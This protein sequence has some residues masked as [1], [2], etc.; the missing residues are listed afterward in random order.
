M[1]RP[2]VSSV[3]REAMG[4]VPKVLLASTDT[5]MAVTN[6]SGVDIREQEAVLTVHI[7]SMRNEF[8]DTT[9]K[10][11]ILGRASDREEALEGQPLFLSPIPAGFPVNVSDDVATKVD[12]H[13]YVVRNPASTFFLKATGLSM[14]GAGIHDG[15][16]LVVDRS[17]PAEHNRIVIAAVEGE[18]TVKRLKR[19]KDGVFLVPENPDY[20]EIEITHCEYVHIWGVVS[21]VVHKV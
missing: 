5:A 10:L 8:M 12:L 14:I 7:G 13:R 18:L 21:F 2:V 9:M 15:D 3:G 11:E 4:T 6:V 19:R 1:T 16:L 17:L 20:P